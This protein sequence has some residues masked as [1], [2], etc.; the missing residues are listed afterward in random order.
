MTAWPTHR[1]RRVEK[2]ARIRWA[3]RQAALERRA[4]RVKPR[5]TQR[6]KPRE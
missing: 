4:R 1:R 5:D 3:R 2:A 6:V